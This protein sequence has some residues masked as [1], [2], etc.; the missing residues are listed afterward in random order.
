MPPCF[1]VMRWTL[2]VHPNTLRYRVRKAVALSGISVD[3]P[4]QRLVAMLR[5]RLAVN[6]GPV[7][8]APFPAR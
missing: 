5:L 3:D 1:W 8:E 4:D 7:A 6:G 2:N